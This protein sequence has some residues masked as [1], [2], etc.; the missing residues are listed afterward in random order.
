MSKCGRWQGGTGAWLACPGGSGGRSR[1]PYSWERGLSGQFSGT[2]V[3]GGLGALLEEGVLGSSSGLHA[4]LQYPP[5][6][7][8]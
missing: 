6:G 8:Y 1:T 2:E 3:E 5:W 7:L 4:G